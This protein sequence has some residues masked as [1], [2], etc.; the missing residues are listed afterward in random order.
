[1]A[2]RCI[3]RCGRE[4]IRLIG[5]NRLQHLG[6][7]PVILGEAPTDLGDEHLE[8]L[9]AQQAA[10][11]LLALRQRRRDG[12]EVAHEQRQR[13]SGD[14]DIAG[15][16]GNGPVEDV[17]AA[18]K[19]VLDARLLLRLQTGGQRFLDQR[20]LG[21][22]ALLCH[23]VE[24]PRQRARQIK[25]V[26]L[27]A[28]YNRSPGNWSTLSRSSSPGAACPASSAGAG[29]SRRSANNGRSL[30]GRSALSFLRRGRSRA[31]GGLSSLLPLDSTSSDQT[32]SRRTSVPRVCPDQSSRRAT[33]VSAQP[34]AA[35]FG[36]GSRRA[37][38]LRSA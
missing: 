3:I 32:F 19:G 30:S 37:R 6:Y 8:A 34:V 7:E 26:A 4:Q 12:Q 18:G 14:G 15:H 36:A 24:L 33:G 38:K 31:R 23:Q 16:C 13:L 2:Q 10:R 1:M 28:H 20:R 25:S 11:L 5:G 29:S 9:L 27:L 35:N 22:Q 21:A 17:E